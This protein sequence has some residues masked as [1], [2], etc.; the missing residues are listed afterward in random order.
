MKRIISLLK[1]IYLTRNFGFFDKRGIPYEKPYPVL[2]SMW[3][4]ILKLE[5]FYDFT[6]RYVPL[7][8]Y[9]LYLYNIYLEQ[10]LNVYFTKLLGAELPTRLQLR[11]SGLCLEILKT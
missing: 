4:V 8:Y 7:L 3:R 6:Q 5:N 9:L 2:G 11:P 1:M 10:P